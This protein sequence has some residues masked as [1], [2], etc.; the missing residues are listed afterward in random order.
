MA[1]ILLL[2]PS[3]QENINRFIPYA[4]LFLRAALKKRGHTVKIV[5]F[6]LGKEAYETFRHELLKGPDILGISLFCGPAVSLAQKASQLCRKLAPNTC[7][8]WGGI[9]PTIAPEMVLKEPY[10]DYVI[11]FEAEESFPD[12]ADALARGDK[13]YDTPNLAYRDGDK[14]VV[15]PPPSEVLDLSDFPAIEFTDVDSP[16]YL[17]TQLH[18]GKRIVSVYTSRGCP[19]RCTFCYNLYY[20]FCKWRSF[21]VAWTLDTIDKL[22]QTFQ[23]DGLFAFDDNFCADNERTMEIL[24]GVRSRGHNL[25]WWVE[26]RADQILN[27]GVDQLKKLYDLG[28]REAYVGAESG[29]DRILKLFNKRVKAHE[30]RAANKMLAETKIIPRYSFIIGAPTEKPE[31]TLETIDLAVTMMDDN[32][33]TSIWQFN[34]YTPYPG[35]PLYNL[36][37]KKGFSSYNSLDDWNVGWTLRENMIS[38]T[39]MS[40]KELSTI[41]YA[42]LFQQ[43]DDALKNRPFLFNA[44]FKTLR[45]SFAYRLRHHLFTPFLDTWAVGALYQGTFMLNRWRMRRLNKHIDEI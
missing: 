21:P 1:R 33:R 29:C 25:K 30:I 36:A 37:V 12:F 15:K 24:E 8:V 18:F 13:P 7:I 42:A 6:Q 32:P 22:V 43:P 28:I 38:S 14:I 45:T 19:Y 41:R 9:L 16:K 10:V 31:E 39:T 34:Q 26:L 27:M 40:N 4:L 17:S 44:S 20:N 35:T 11:R 5:D 2:S 23:I 3:P